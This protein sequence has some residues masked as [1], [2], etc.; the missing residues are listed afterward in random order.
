MVKQ[1]VILAAGKGERLRPLTD[2]LPKPMLKVGGKPLLEHTLGNLRNQGIKDIF[3]NLHYLP[4]KITDYFSDGKKWGVKITYAYEPELLGTAGGIKNFEKYLGDEFLVIYGDM[5][6][7]VDYQK[8]FDFYKNKKRAAGAVMVAPADRLDG[9][10]AE[11]NEEQ[12]FKNYYSRPHPPGLTADHKFLLNAVYV[13]SKEILDF[14]PAAAYCDLDREVLPKI[15][16]QGQPL[17]GYVGQES[18]FD[19]GTLERLEK[20]VRR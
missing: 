19:I 17:Y 4:E 13:F 6:S 1:A 2:N 3:I 5:W 15:L 10:L 16:A 7:E 11:L 14:I 12:R 8:F 9:D 20:A 18:V